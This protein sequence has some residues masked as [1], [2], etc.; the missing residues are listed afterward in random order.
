MVSFTI[1]LCSLRD[2]NGAGS[3]YLVA[4]R[5]TDCS[6]IPSLHGHANGDYDPKAA[7]WPGASVMSLCTP[8]ILEALLENFPNDAI[9]GILGAPINPEDALLE[10]IPLD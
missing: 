8:Y 6:G 10:S 2:R 9:V 7:V 4:E 3:E 1:M 5:L